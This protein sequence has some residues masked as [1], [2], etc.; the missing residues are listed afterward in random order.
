[1]KTAEELLKY[2]DDSNFTI[3]MQIIKG[4]DCL[5][6]IDTSSF[7]RKEWCEKDD[8]LKIVRLALDFK[9][10][11]IIA[12]IDGLIDEIQKGYYE[13]S[14]P[15]DIAQYDKGYIKALTEL[16]QKIGDL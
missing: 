13:I 9:A 4:V 7:R 2:K 1:M 11:E 15:F 10:L 16:K 5:S 8:V 12:L 3:E 6:Y 14:N